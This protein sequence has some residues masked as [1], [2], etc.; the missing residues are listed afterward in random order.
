M[1]TCTCGGKLG[2]IEM[3]EKLKPHENQTFVSQ[4]QTH[5]MTLVFVCRISCLLAMESAGKESHLSP[6][7]INISLDSCWHRLMQT[8][9]MREYISHTT[10]SCKTSFAGWCTPKTGLYTRQFFFLFE[11]ELQ[12]VPHKARVWMTPW[13]VKGQLKA[14]QRT[15]ARIRG[16]LFCLIQFR[17]DKK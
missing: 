11:L 2:S 6:G 13:G 8:H 1:Q 17:W 3:K 9:R 16:V 4:S 10:S 14:A 12:G 15:I 7:S 5:K